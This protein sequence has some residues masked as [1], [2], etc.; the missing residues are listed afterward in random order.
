LLLANGYLF[1]LP[2]ERLIPRHTRRRYRGAMP[3]NTSLL[4]TLSDE[5]AG[6]V[7]RAT[8]LT[9]A[10]QGPGRRPITATI[11]GPELAVGIAHVIDADAVR[12]RT[13]AG[14]GLDATVA[15][16]DDTRD[17]VLLRVP[18]LDEPA[19]PLQNALPRMGELVISASRTWN[20]HPTSSL[21][22]VGS[23]G[24]PLRIGRG[25][26][27][28]QVIHADVGP[29]PG[30]SGSPLVNMAG[31]IVAIVNAGLARGIPL[32][33]PIADVQQSVASL[34][35]HG[36]IRRG[37]IGVGLQPVQLPERQTPVRRRG[38]LVVGVEGGSPADEA[39]LFVGDVIVAA[40]GEAT[41]DTDELQRWLTGDRVGSALAIEIVRGGHAS[42]VSITIGDRG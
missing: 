13:I 33:L 22:V 18:G 25:A 32:A 8:A 9:L 1:A 26:A 2:P 37:F 36:R 27:L 42:T 12:V 15:G 28:P 6:L 21:G 11:I 7:A 3:K 35:Q 34:G 39:G 17:L 29:T 24:G 38:L 40:E 14:R 23:I 30:I 10:V 20:G 41:A 16:R 4:H 19:P 5:V 31:E